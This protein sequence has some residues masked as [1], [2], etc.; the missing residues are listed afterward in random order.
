M[1]SYICSLWLYLASNS[2]WNS[3]G[4]TWINISNSVVC[5]SYLSHQLCMPVSSLSPSSG[6]PSGFPSRP[7][8]FAQ[9]ISFAQN[10]LLFPQL[11]PVHPLDLNSDITLSFG[12]HSLRKENLRIRSVIRICNYHHDGTPEERY[13]KVGT[14]KRAPCN[15]GIQRL[16]WGCSHCFWILL[17]CL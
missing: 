1:E 4:V 14:T 11:P 7:T 8:A 2:W 13:G 10:I 3:V 5:F 6:P 9:S 15:L 16:F 12:K 17:P